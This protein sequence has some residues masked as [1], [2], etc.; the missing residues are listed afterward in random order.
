MRYVI[1]IYDADTAN[2]SPAPPDPN[3]AA[4]TME[5]YNAYGQML[6]DRGAFL[7]GE[8]L[9]PVTSATTLHASGGHTVTT[10]GPYAETK[11]GLGG[12]YLIEARDLDDALDLAGRCPGLGYGA[13]IEVRPV[14]DFSAQPADRAMG[15]AAVD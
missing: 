8:A 2:P 5:A 11:E 12:F 14:W 15:A 4:A 9:Q 6:Q 1:L 13:S 3:E 7:G 10:D